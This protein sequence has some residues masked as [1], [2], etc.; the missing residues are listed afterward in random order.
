MVGSAHPTVS[1][2]DRVGFDF[3]EGFAVDEAGDFD[4]GGGGADFAEDAAVNAGH[5]FPFAHVDDVHPRANNMLQ[6]AAKGFDGGADDGERAGRL[7]AD[8][9]R[10]AAIGIDADRAG[11]GDRVA[12][13]DRAAV[14]HDGFPLR[15]A[16][17]ALTAGTILDGDVDIGHVILVD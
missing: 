13:A 6:L 8:A 10:V 4:D 12:A 1:S 16:R 15:A 17:S 7:V 3:D 5:F 9:F 11:N 2:Y 14:A